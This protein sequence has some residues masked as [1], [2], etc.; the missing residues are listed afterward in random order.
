MAAD[1]DADREADTATVTYQFDAPRTLWYEWTDDL[2]RES[3]EDRLLTLI[4]QDTAQE[5]VDDGRMD[6]PT[7]ANLETLGG[8]IRFNATQA[9]ACARREQTADAIDHLQ[10]ITEL[11][12]AV[13]ESQD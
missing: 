11:G 1:S 9:I 12:E 6:D 7:L 3:I 5:F 4:E 8:Y 2:G 10:R 13:A